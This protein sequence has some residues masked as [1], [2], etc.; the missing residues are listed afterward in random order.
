[1]RT[2]GMLLVA[3]ALLFGTGGVSVRAASDPPD[4]TEPLGM[5]P[6]DP[7][8]AGVRAAG[9]RTSGGVVVDLDALD[10]A[11]SGFVPL[12]AQGY[13]YAPPGLWRPPVKVRSPEPTEPVDSAA[14]A[15]PAD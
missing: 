12:N 14:P 8:A 11:P 2:L 3:A 1:V 6:A 5:T 15:A 10:P 7:A 13:N 9:A 4:P